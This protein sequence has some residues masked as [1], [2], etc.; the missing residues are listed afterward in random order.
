MSIKARRRKVKNMRM[1]NWIKIQR[2][3]FLKEE[4][5]FWRSA[6]IFLSG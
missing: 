5:Y 3:I 6:S 1:D 4:K 2:N